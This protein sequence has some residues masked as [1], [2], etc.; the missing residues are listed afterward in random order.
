MSKK[1]ILRGLYKLI[2]NKGYRSFILFYMLIAILVSII[3]NTIAWSTYGGPGIGEL[4]IT[5]TGKIALIS[6]YH[7]PYLLGFGVFIAKIIFL[8]RKE[9]KI[10]TYL[11]YVLACISGIILGTIIFWLDTF[12]TRFMWK[13][14]WSLIHIIREVG[15]VDWPIP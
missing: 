3:W 5:H 2:E 10:K 1:E 6:I 15:W 13:V 12:T 4:E 11:L 7:I 8:Y 14:I 9:E